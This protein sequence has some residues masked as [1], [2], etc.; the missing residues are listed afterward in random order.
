MCH[1]DL[2]AAN[3]LG[4]WDRSVALPVLDS[5]DVVHEDHEVLVFAL[6][7]AFRLGSVSARHFGG[8]V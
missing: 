1:E 7:V 5:S 2:K 3:D 4:Q 6:V 8:C